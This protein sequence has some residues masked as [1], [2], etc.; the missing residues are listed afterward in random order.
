MFTRLAVIVGALLLTAASVSAQ[1]RDPFAVDFSA[2]YDVVYHEAGVTTNVGAHFDIASTVT[3]DVPYLVVLGE[4]GVNH[5]D[6]GSVSS[7]LGGARL[8]FPNQSPRVLPFA[9]LLVGLYHCGVCD[10]N[11]FA[12]Q[13]GA[14]LDFK[15]G[16]AV[17]VRAQIDVRH[18]FDP[19]SFNSVRASAGL[20]LPLNR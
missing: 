10:L 1:S 4:V 17:R 15:T 9:Q 3:R 19:F 18:V 7:F 20:V 11:D 16:H 6:N 5:F 8:R 2:N 13:A 12:L 14:G